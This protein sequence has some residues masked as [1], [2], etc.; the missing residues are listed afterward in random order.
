MWPRKSRLKTGSAMIF[1]R[2]LP[3]HN[4]ERWRQVHGKSTPLMLPMEDAELLSRWLDPGFDRVE[5]FRSLLEPRFPQSVTCVPV[6]RPG[7]QRVLGEGFE[8]EGEG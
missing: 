4:D 8:I 1:P 6:E 3:P 5:E 2:F 7:D